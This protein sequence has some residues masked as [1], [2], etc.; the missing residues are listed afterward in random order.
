MGHLR[1]LPRGR[2]GDSAERSFA[3]LAVAV[4]AVCSRE[5][6]RWGSNW[7]S[8]S[9]LSGRPQLE[10]LSG[11][12]LAHEEQQRWFMIQQLTRALDEA[13]LCRALLIVVA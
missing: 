9:M 1:G 3:C 2:D 6:S 8:E 12:L 7:F 13:D 11:R 4:S 5:L 10:Q